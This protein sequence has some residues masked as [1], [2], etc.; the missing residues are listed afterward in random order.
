MNA[1]TPWTA[2]VLTLFPVM[3]RGPLG[4]ALAG[5]SNP[6]AMGANRQ[7]PNF[8]VVLGEVQDFLSLVVRERSR[9]PEADGPILAG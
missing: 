9:V 1:P 6:L 8:V 4:H 3:F 5:R 7:A 2:S